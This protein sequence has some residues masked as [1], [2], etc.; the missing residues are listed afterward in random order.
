[1]HPQAAVARRTAEVAT[2]LGARH[3]FLVS[4]GKAALTL[5]LRALSLLRP[6]KTEV[7]V[8]AYTCYSVPSAVVS[9]GLRPVPADVAPETL[10]FSREALRRVV[11]PSTLCVLPDHLFGRPADLE[12]QAGL[13]RETATFLVEDAAQAL[14]GMYQGKWLGTVGDAGVFSFGR[15]KNVTCGSGG[16]IVTDSDALAGALRRSVG[17]LPDPPAADGFL[18][19]HKVA[20][21][22]PWIRPSCYWLPAGLPFLGLG[23]TRYQETFPIFRLSGARAGLLHRWRSNLAAGNAARRAN[24]R[25]YLDHLPGTRSVDRSVA[26]LRFPVLLESSR[27]RESVLGL[28]RRWGLGISA[29]YPAAVDQIPELQSGMQGAPCPAARDVARRLVTLPTH[30]LVRG[31]D[32]ERIV[33]LLCS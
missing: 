21:T 20:L 9:A 4:S 17:M 7:V 8:P 12:F 15:G 16:A 30:H 11:G 32:L 10:D 24:A 22:V 31:V 27:K 23:E 25:Y 3:V 33:D 13:C 28:S 5:V 18:E 29:M 19:W 14:G 2:T 6:G 1:L 26:F